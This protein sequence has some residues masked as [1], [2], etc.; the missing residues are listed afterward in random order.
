V[1]LPRGK[2]HEHQLFVEPNPGKTDATFFTDRN[3]GELWEGP[4][5][6]VPESQ[7][8]YAIACRPLT[9]L[10]ATLTAAMSLSGARLRM[11]RGFSAATEGMLDASGAEQALHDR[12]WPPTCPRCG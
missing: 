1:L 9:E 12:N 5:F 6:G 10:A 3:K 8:R 4:R 11:L 2:G 7:S